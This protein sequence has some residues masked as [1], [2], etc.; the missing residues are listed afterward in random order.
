MRFSR[1]P[2]LP[3]ALFL[4]AACATPGAVDDR[5]RGDEASAAKAPSTAAAD[6]RVPSTVH[7]HN[8]SGETVDMNLPWRPEAPTAEVAAGARLRLEDVPADTPFLAGLGKSTGHPF[9]VVL[10]LGPGQTLSVVL[11]PVEATL[12]AVNG[13]RQA[14][15][16]AAGGTRRRLEPGVSTRIAMPIGPSVQARAARTDGSASF[17]RTFD[18]TMRRSVRWRIV[19]GT[20]SV[21]VVNPLSEPLTIYV[22]ARRV[23]ETPAGTEVAFTGVEAGRRLLEAVGRD[24]GAV[25]RQRVR[26]E[27][28]KIQLWNVAASGSE[29][30]AT[31][32]APPARPSPDDVLGA[33]VVFNESADSIA[34][35]VDGRPH[36]RVEPRSHQGFGALATGKRNLTVVSHDARWRRTM[37][38]ELR[39]GEIESVTIPA[40][41]AV[42]VLDND[43]DEAVRV[44]LGQELLGQ[45]TASTRG[46]R[47]AVR[48]GLRRVTVSGVRTGREIMRVVTL[49]AGAASA[50]HFPSRR[51]RLVIVNASGQPVDV[52]AGRLE[53]GRVATGDH[54]VVEDLEAGLIELRARDLDGRLTHAEQRRVGPGETTSW[55]LAG[56]PS[57]GE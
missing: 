38:V 32:A 28:G 31:A 5:S 52:T 36:G 2:C 49:L 4:V 55:E 51:V 22:D 34:V 23:G 11:R 56:T 46:V 15:V 20:G 7:I 21:R 35:R 10:G 8:R 45:V 47:F 54:L 1:L 29:S 6:G 41:S 25:L 26:V 50:V 57:P 30:A 17:Q 24:S 27:S 44:R 16:V 12:E 40:P 43:A 9:R 18:T 33:L 14:V 53:L 42:L 37:S 3:L 48:A 13:T 19:S 39:P